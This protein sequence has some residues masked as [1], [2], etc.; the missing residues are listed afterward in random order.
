MGLGHAWGGS[1]IALALASAMAG[2]AAMMAWLAVRE[3]R[4]E[5]PL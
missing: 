3:L 5:E 1:W 2:A 4:P